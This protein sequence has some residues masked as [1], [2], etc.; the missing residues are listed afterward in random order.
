MGDV[1]KKGLVLPLGFEVMR[2]FEQTGIMLKEIIIKKQHN[3][4][5]SA[6]WGASGIKYNFLLLAHEYLFVFQKK[7]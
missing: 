1:R 3:C 4:Q 2:I 5:S 6:R 7:P